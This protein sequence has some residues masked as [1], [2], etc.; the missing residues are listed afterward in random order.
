VIKIGPDYEKNE[1][2]VGKE[3]LIKAIS[4]SCGKS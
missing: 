1:L 2:G 4:K 3:I